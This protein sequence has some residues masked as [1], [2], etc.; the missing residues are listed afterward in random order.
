MHLT[1][2]FLSTQDQLASRLLNLPPHRL[3]NGNMPE[4]LL[5]YSYQGSLS[6]LMALLPSRKSLFGD[7]LPV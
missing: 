4:K 6:H 1:A 7:K 2:A 5:L 3:S